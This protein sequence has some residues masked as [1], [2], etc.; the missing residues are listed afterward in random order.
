LLVEGPKPDGRLGT[1]GTRR[2]GG[3]RRPE[4]EATSAPE[5]VEDGHVEEVDDPEADQQ[6]AETVHEQAHPV[7]AAL[8]VHNLVRAEQQRRVPQVEL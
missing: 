8:D 2:G 1:G 7:D 4:P 6:H 5:A 3:G